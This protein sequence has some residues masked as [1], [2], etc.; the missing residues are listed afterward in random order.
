MNHLTSLLNEKYKEIKIIIYNN[1]TRRNMIVA[2]IIAIL[3]IGII[4][5]YSIFNS[6][7][8]R[9]YD[10][11]YQNAETALEYERLLARRTAQSLENEVGEDI[12]H[13]LVLGAETTDDKVLHQ[14]HQ[15]IYQ[16]AA[17]Q[18]GSAGKLV[19]YHEAQIRAKGGIASTDDLDRVFTGEVRDEI[20]YKLIT[21]KTTHEPKLEE[22]SP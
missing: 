20:A 18:A 17:N 9:N 21:G 1:Y 3:M 10:S 16:D 7:P 6:N 15:E 11:Y 22:T 8:S 4:L 2:S 5:I 13:S 12:Y 14:E 19:D